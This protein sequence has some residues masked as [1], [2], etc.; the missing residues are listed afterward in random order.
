MQ[1]VCGLLHNMLSQCCVFCYLLCSNYSF[2]V[3][4]LV[5]HFLFSILCVTCFCIVS[6]HVYSS[7]FSICVQ[8]TGH[9]HRVETQLQL[10][11]IISKSRHALL[12]C[13]S[14]QYSPP[15]PSSCHILGLFKSRGSS[16]FN[17]LHPP[18]TSLACSNHEA[19]RHLISSI[20][21]SH[22]WPV[23]ITRLLVI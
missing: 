23:Q 13:P 3:C 2:Y 1:S 20:L 11:N 10:I 9:C 5:L 21:L 22:P 17:F 4:F 19:P 15:I 6:P 14:G 18:V 7:L 16:S 12:S 8:V